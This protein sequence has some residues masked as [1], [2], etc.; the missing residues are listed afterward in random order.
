MLK[1]EVETQAEII[2][3]LTRRIEEARQAH[4]V[5]QRIPP[6]KVFRYKAIYWT[7]VTVYRA[8]HPAA[9]LK[10]WKRG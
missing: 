9:T 10:S 8:I 7:K 4:V 3:V 2:R 1:R 6:V 5:E